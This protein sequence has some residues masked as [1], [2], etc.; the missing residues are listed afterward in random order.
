MSLS[1]ASR[2]GLG[3]HGAAE[4]AAAGLLALSVLYI[5][6]NESLAN[7]QSLWLCAAFAGLA[8]TLARV[9]DAPG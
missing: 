9:R 1:L 2:S 6:P 4:L 5:V 7:W 3:R 8:L